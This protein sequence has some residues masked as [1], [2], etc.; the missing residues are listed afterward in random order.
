M[1]LVSGRYTNGMEAE[2]IHWLRDNVPRFGKADISIGDDA[3]VLP[4]IN[5]R[6]AITTD[7]LMDGVHFLATE[8]SL[9]DIGYKAMA[10]NVSDLA[11]MAAEPV[12]AVVSLTIP[13]SMQLAEI[14]QLYEGMFKISRRFQI[15]IVGGDTNRWAGPLTIAI[16]VF[17]KERGTSFWTRSDAKAGDIILVTGPL[18]GSLLR[19]HFSFLPRVDEAAYLQ[20]NYNV[21]AATD[22]TDGLARDLAN[23]IEA[24]QCGAVLDC[25]CIPVSNDARELA[26]S[27]GRTPLDHAMNDGEDFELLFTTSAEES[28]RMLVDPKLDV[29][30]IGRCTDD[31]QLRQR[32]GNGIEQVLERGGYQH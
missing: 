1:R 11:A 27:S 20:D 10:V 24:S 8:L 22:I 19:R 32:D 30:V 31:R 23:I 17:G 12:A 14:Q 29:V 13:R 2:L 3:A 15:E 26:K 16:T 28:K 7:T 9:E 21:H 18:G 5:S 4:V 6:T 25:D